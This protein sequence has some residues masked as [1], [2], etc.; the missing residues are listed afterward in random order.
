LSSILWTRLLGKFKLKTIIRFP[1]TDYSLFIHIMPCVTLHCLVHLLPKDYQAKHYPAIHT[2]LYSEKTSPEHYSL[3]QMMFWASLPYAVWQLSYHFLISVRRRDKIAAGR[4]TSFTWLRRSF[5]DVWLGKI[6]LSLPESLQEPAYM[7]IQY[8]YALLTMVPCPLWFWSRWASG[9]FLGSVFAWSVWNGA[10]YYI[11]VFGTRFQKELEALK[12]DVAKWQ[13]ATPP[14]VPG[15]PP[16]SP[17]ELDLK[18]PG[19][20]AAATS[21]AELVKNPM[22]EMDDLNGDCSKDKLPGIDGGIDMDTVEKKP[23]AK[24]VETKKDQ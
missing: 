6:V 17:S 2:I 3:G 18:T 23:K 4:P 5:A 13:N 12:K 19:L 16:F 24:S 20:H 22:M 10:T 15:S 1:L 9:L 7:I 14:G 8:L 11:D 21:M